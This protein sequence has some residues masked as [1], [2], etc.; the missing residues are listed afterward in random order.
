MGTS[1]QTPVVLEVPSVPSVQ[2]NL[3]FQKNTWTSRD[4]LK[5]PGQSQA[6]SDSH[7]GFTCSLGAQNQRQGLRNADA[8][9]PESPGTV[10]HSFFIINL[11]YI[12]SN[13]IQTTFTWPNAGFH[14]RYWI[15]KNHS[16]TIY[17]AFYRFKSQKWRK[18]LLKY[19]VHLPFPLVNLW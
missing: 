9:R 3:G 2:K 7:P 5:H 15:I 13:F 8:G 16:N 4:R 11:G 10:I 6:I 1:P 12:V 19:E 18:T 14:S 17:Q